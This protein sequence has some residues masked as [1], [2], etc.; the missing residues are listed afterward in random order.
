MKYINTTAKEKGNEFN[1]IPGF[2]CLI[3]KAAPVKITN[4]NK[5]EYFLYPV[6]FVLKIRLKNQKEK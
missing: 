1:K 4:K 3:T 6:L 5:G 2:I